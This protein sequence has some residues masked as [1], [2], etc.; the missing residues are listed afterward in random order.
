MD[1]QEQEELAGA[2]T[3]IAH[4]LSAI[5]VPILLALILWRVW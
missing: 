5:A 3:Q 4:L 1:R 2:L